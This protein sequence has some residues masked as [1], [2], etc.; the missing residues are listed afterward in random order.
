M[1]FTGLKCAVART[2]HEPVIPDFQDFYYSS[3]GSGDC[4]VELISSGVRFIQA[5]LSLMSRSKSSRLMIS[6]PLGTEAVSEVL[7]AV[8]RLNIA[9]NSIARYPRVTGSGSSIP[10]G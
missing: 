9:V 2:G 5:F 8:N 7:G 3:S 4:S 6:S 1:C 10:S